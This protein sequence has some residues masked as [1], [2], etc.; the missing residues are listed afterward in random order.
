MSELRERHISAVDG[1]PD[2]DPAPEPKALDAGDL[3][4]VKETEKEAK[5]ETQI[6][7]EVIRTMMSVESNRKWFYELL[8]KC[9]IGSNPFSADPI[10][11][12]FACGELNIGQQIFID[13]QAACP[14]LYLKM[15]EENR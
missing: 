10:S 4:S 7:A 2:I 5:T 1:E 3:R 15:M 9:H 14:D 13:L 8:T 12:A 6:R 11:M